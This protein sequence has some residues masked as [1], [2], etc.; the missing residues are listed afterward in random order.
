MNCL[1]P[2]CTPLNLVTTALAIA[3][4]LAGCSGGREISSTASYNPGYGPFDQNG[5]YVEAWADKPVRQH[6]WGT[7]PPETATQLV[8]RKDPP[9]SASRKKPTEK[10]PPLVASQTPPSRPAPA[11]LPKPRPA[12]PKP[13]PKP[14]IR[15]TVVKGDTLYSL[16][17]RYGTSVGAIQR[18]NGISGTTIRIGQ[19]LRIPR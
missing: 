7:K 11:V 2:T 9:V 10:R 12:S 4:L 13:A 17:R 5:N 18:A 16:G 3:T 1:F 14:T 19:K 8:A 15:H 6:R